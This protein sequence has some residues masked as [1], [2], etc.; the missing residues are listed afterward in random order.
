MGNRQTRQRARGHVTIL[1]LPVRHKLGRTRNGHRS[2]R[3]REPVRAFALRFNHHLSV[4]LHGA[5]PFVPHEGHRLLGWQ[6][7]RHHQDA[8]DHQAC[9]A[10]AGVA[11]HRDLNESP[12]ISKGRQNT[13]RL[14]DEACLFFFRFCRQGHLSACTLFRTKDVCHASRM[15]I[16]PRGRRNEIK[17]RN[18]LMGTGNPT[19]NNAP[20]PLPEATTSRLERCP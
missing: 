19:A 14:R 1:L 12:T 9:P 17:R 15:E 3:A 13:V 5:R 18:A 7:F 20:C 4:G 8:R 16:Q 6:V 10:V 11:V 2:E